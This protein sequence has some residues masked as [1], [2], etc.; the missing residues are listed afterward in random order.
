MPRE[1][2]LNGYLQQWR[3]T[4]EMRQDCLDIGFTVGT[5]LFGAYEDSNLSSESGD[6]GKGLSLLWAASL[7]SRVEVWSAHLVASHRFRRLLRSLPTASRPTRYRNIRT[8]ILNMEPSRGHY[9]LTGY[10]MPWNL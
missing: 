9:K 2:E 7:L 6:T 8:K 4:Y 3:C 1:H 5:I 10:L